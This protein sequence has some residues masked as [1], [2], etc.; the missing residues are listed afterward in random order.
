MCRNALKTK[1]KLTKIALA[2]LSAISLSTAALFAGHAH[3]LSLSKLSVSSNLGQ[4]LNAEID[5][6]LDPGETIETIKAKVASP[7]IYQSQGLDYPQILTKVNIAVL[8]K[9]DKVVLKVTSSSPVQD[10]YVDLLVDVNSA[11]GRIVREYVFLLDP[12]GAATPQTLAVTQAPQAVVLPATTPVTDSTPPVTV[13]VS[14]PAVQAPAGAVGSTEP[15]KP[16]KTSP[17]KTESSGKQ[18]TVKPGD[19][20]S[21]IAGANAKPGVSIE[22]M[23]VALYRSNPDAFIN[24]NMNLLKSGVK[25][26]VPDAATAETVPSEEAKKEVKSQVENWAGYQ[27]RLANQAKPVARTNNSSVTT[28]QV[29]TKVED[30]AKKAAA[31]EKLTVSQGSK[32]SATEN[33]AADKKAL[34]EN[35]SR[36]DSLNKTV[37]KLGNA[38]TLQNQRLSEAQTA[39]AKATEA[40]KT[41]PVKAPAGSVE[42]KKPVVAAAAPNV[43]ATSASAPTAAA[44]AEVARAEAAKVEAAKVEAAKVEAAKVE[45]AKAEA[46]K[47][48]AAKAEAAKAEAAK[49]EAAKAEA[50]K[51]EATKAEATK[52]EAAKAASLK[53]EPAS[54]SAAPATPPVVPAPAPAVK[55]P[56]VQQPVQEYEAP[57]IMGFITDNP[58]I[59][60]GVLGLGGLAAAGLWWSRRRK[61]DIPELEQGAVVNTV[62]PDTV[63]GN[64]GSA[65]GKAAPLTTS[66]FSRSGM[67]NIDMGDVDPVAEAEVYIAYGRESQAEEILLEAIKHK[68]R[69]ELRAKLVEV[70]GLMG[71]RDAFDREANMLHKMQANQPDKWAASSAL[72]ARFY[73]THPLLSGHVD[74]TA[75]PKAMAAQGPATGI[76]EL[77]NTATKADKF[78]MDFE[79]PEMPPML[80]RKESA[81]LKASPLDIPKG[82]VPTLRKPTPSTLDDFTPLSQIATLSPEKPTTRIGARAGSSSSGGGNVA[83][84]R[85]L[86][87]LEDD[88]NTAMKIGNLPDERF[89]SFDNT[90]IATGGAKGLSA[91]LK[92]SSL[93]LSMSNDRKIDGAP[94]SNWS[95]V[96]TKLD[97]AKAYEEMGDKDGAREILIEVLQEG[98]TSQKSSAQDMMKR[99]GV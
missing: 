76:G 12:P 39:A 79:M 63:F 3:A 99:L 97:L 51:A 64:S 82:E 31:K 15:A 9:G 61:K 94:V 34:A 68:D 5:I 38:I 41:E 90:T 47:A 86:A 84:Q 29:T 60:A 71:Q 27:S 4:P 70:Y 62:G 21:I 16:T 83:L 53:N 1:Y 93:D 98:D 52:A 88:L 45:A 40:K 10:P 81:A 55:A 23:L 28:G 77:V 36:Q 26:T 46:A 59:P 32:N 7:D 49:A 11:S 33:A 44:K 24:Q 57:G 58:L 66:Q 91:S 8:Q 89:V 18:V 22:Q 73:P 72:I 67:G 13:T 25:L 85:E 42:P 95:D 2:T 20:L 74:T 17:A 48:E 35:K 14:P 6:S 19:T 37:D 80:S 69:A 96:A 87:S 65:Q 78:S 30:S 43:A 56:I 50:A 75:S 92:A 54:T